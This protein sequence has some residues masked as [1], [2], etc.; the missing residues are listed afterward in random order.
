MAMETRFTPQ[1]LDD[2]AW[3]IDR[4]GIG[5]IPS[6]TLRDLG[7][8]ASR[9]DASAV[10]IAVMADDGEPSCRAVAP[11]TRRMRRQP[12]LASPPD[13]A[14]VATLVRER[15]PMTNPVTAQTQRERLLDPVDRI[16]EILFGLIMVLTF[17]GA[18]SVHTDQRDEMLLV[19]AAIGCN[20]AWGIV[21]G[22]MFVMMGLVERAR[23][24]RL[25]HD[26]RVSDAAR[27]RDLLA[28]E[29]P[30]LISSTFDDDEM[31]TMRVSVLKVPEPEGSLLTGDDVRGG[32]AVAVL[33]FLSTFPVVVPF[34]WIDDQRIAVR[35]S[36][37]VALVMMFWC[38]H[39]LGGYAGIRRRW[40]VGVAM[41]AVG[42]VLV[43]LTIMLGG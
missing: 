27:G 35:T 26:V 36:N 3:R 17:T 5:S 19:V 12:P 8:A 25:L 23:G 1:V 30:S 13:H 29:L 24:R 37:A 21:D 32:V 31:E 6:S 33:V 16:S 42:V 9:A 39:Q 40:T 34:L 11:A 7:L 28:R 2:I 15:R 22:V 20:L 18:I 4:H 10:L 43:A 41:A 14:Q 38:G